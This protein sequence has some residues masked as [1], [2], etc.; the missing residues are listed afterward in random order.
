MMGVLEQR[1]PFSAK[2][3]RFGLT[4]AIDHGR[5]DLQRGGMRAMTPLADPMGQTIRPKQATPVCPAMARR[6]PARLTKAGSCAQGRMGAGQG[7][8]DFM[9]EIGKPIS[10]QDDF[11]VRTFIDHPSRPAVLRLR[12]R[13]VPRT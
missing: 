6:N 3:D 5:S 10:K 7:G 11:A 12:R 2:N 1:V 13:P 8:Q 4:V 9:H